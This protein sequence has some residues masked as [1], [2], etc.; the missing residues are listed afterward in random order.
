MQKRKE[1]TERKKRG[2]KQLTCVCFSHLVG[3]RR[4]QQQKNATTVT[5]MG[6]RMAKVSQMGLMLS[7][8]DESS[9][10]HDSIDM[11]SWL[12]GTLIVQI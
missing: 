12:G 11:Y 5:R 3:F 7:P 9:L 6:R 2:G 10:F 1:T 8:S 4:L